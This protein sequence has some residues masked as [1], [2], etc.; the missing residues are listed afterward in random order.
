V[1]HLSHVQSVAQIPARKIRNFQIFTRRFTAMRARSPAN[2]ARLPVLVGI[3]I[4]WPELCGKGP[5]ASRCPNDDPGVKRMTRQA[6]PIEVEIN[7]TRFAGFYAV[8]SSMLTVWHAFLGSRTRTLCEGF[9]P[10]DAE[11]LMHELYRA[12]RAVLPSA[13]LGQR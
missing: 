10:A 2:V 3:A 1:Q 12:S 5:W 7:G 13:V 6:M 4:D 9:H 8:E 11:K